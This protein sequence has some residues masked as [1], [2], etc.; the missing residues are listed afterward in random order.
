MKTSWNF[1]RCKFHCRYQ[2]FPFPPIPSQ[3]SGPPFAK[4]SIC[5]TKGFKNPFLASKDE[6]EPKNC[7]L[8]RFAKH[9]LSHLSGRTR[10]GEKHS[11][12]FPSKKKRYMKQ[13]EHY[14]TFQSEGTTNK[15]E[16]NKHKI[17]FNFP[18]TRLLLSEH[19]TSRAQ[20]ILF[21]SSN[22]IV[23]RIKHL[24]LATQTILFRGINMHFSP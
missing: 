10:P 16:V 3:T 23:S 7:I 19:L 17:K 18:K 24:C 1:L 4:M 8:R 22:N 15:P 20:T 14:H 13:T 21:H 5:Q 6:S 12:H 2:I 11:S 9:T